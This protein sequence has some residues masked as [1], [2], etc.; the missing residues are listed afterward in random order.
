M[1]IF[2]PFFLPNN[3]VLLF[4]NYVVKGVIKALSEKGW[5]IG[6]HAPMDISMNDNR[7]I[8]LRLKEAEIYLRYLLEDI[9]SVQSIRA[10]ITSQIDQLLKEATRK[11][12][13]AGNLL[14]FETKGDQ[15]Y[16][17]RKG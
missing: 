12:R 2:H 13:E 6:Y 11:L 10:S 3:S 5:T 8:K 16:L 17:Q 9:D 7:H 1:G 15:R 14:S 4:A